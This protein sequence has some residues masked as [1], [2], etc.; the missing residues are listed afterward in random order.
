[1][2]G[3]VAIEDEN[4]IS[5]GQN[6]SLFLRST[7]KLQVLLRLDKAVYN[8]NETL[9]AEIVTGADVG[10]ACLNITRGNQTVLTKTFEV[11]GGKGRVEFNLTPDVCGTVEAHAYLIT[12]EGKVLRDACVF[13]VHS[14]NRLEVRVEKQKSTYR[15]GEENVAIDFLVTDSYGQGA[16]SAL[17][18]II[19]DESVYALQDMQPGLEQI[20][21]GLEDRLKNPKPG[22]I[23]HPFRAEDVVSEEHLED[24]RQDVA[25]I[26][27]T[28]AEP[29]AKFNWCNNPSV[30]RKAAFMGNLIA[31]R[32]ALQRHVSRFGEFAEKDP[33]TGKWGFKKGLLKMF[34][35]PQRKDLLPEALIHPLNPDKSITMSDL[36][37]IGNT[38]ALDTWLAYDRSNKKKA[39]W[40]AIWSSAFSLD[41]VEKKDCVYRFRKDALDMLFKSGWLKE[42]HI[43]TA[44]G[45]KL[46]LEKLAKEEKAF[47]PENVALAAEIRRTY[48]QERQE[49]C[50]A[51]YNP[52]E[53]RRRS[54][55]RFFGTEIVDAFD[56]SEARSALWKEIN[57]SDE[58][59][60]RLIP[61]IQEWT[62]TIED[63][64]CQKMFGCEMESRRIGA[65]KVPQPIRIREFFPETLLFEPS[66]ET[67]AYGRARLIIPKLAD[68][69]TTFRMTTSAV[70]RAGGLG[71]ATGS[72]RI[73]QDFFVDID[74]PVALTRGDEV[75][76]PV[77]V[78]NYLKMT[79]TVRVSMEQDDWFEPLSKR[80]KMLSLGPG[81]VTVVYF[82]I[83]ALKVG[84]RKLLVKA[85]G[86]KMSDA[87]RRVIEV[88]PDGKKFEI[89]DNGRLTG[90]IKKKI[91]VPRDAIPG[92]YKIFL[93]IYPGVMGQVTE[94]MEAML[95]M[96]GG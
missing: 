15:P 5:T 95:A 9:S 83:R 67:D 1:M 78:Y 53:W 55:P 58:K 66:L 73:F 39:I 76:I 17:G 50:L 18:I 40:T 57:G 52:P 82:R 2:E 19:V 13:Y 94:G 89:V 90:N 35:A 6:V 29:L 28:S 69:I 32:R 88:V 96:P 20:Y 3:R 51:V 80:T 10:I 46:T 36:V 7:K 84:L 91:S 63:R 22:T 64:H 75:S 70:S 92:S 34:T 74:L 93:K 62:T 56:D 23:D 47:T 43:V 86:S 65:G 72:I 59:A 49:S 27:F 79:Q 38:F 8:A 14:P 60:D 33:A 71:S 87:I 61:K 68:S 54:V 16:Q 4:G 37:G 25:K 41:I 44:N 11:E 48:D 26:I 77:A 42:K 81:Q 85:R 24:A 31:I 45:E 12:P 21:F 30:L